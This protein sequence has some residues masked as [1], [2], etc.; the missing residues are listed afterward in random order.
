MQSQRRNITNAGINVKDF[1]L[2]IP[3]STICEYNT[4]CQLRKIGDFVNGSVLSP[5]AAYFPYAGGF[6]RVYEGCRFVRRCVV[7]DMY[8][9]RSVCCVCVACGVVCGVCGVCGARVYAYAHAHA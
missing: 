8:M 9:W 1:F 4:L 6:F 3:T 2:L 7:C 5:T